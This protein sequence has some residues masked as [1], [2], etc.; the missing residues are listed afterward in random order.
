MSVQRIKIF[1]PVALVLAIG[2]LTGAAFAA[3]A[4][5]VNI[6]TAD[7]TELA[8]LPRVGP[9]L[10]ERI[11]LFR[12]ENGKFKDPAD[13]MLV[14]GIGERTFE[15]MEAYL[16]VEGETTLTQKVRTSDAER[17]LE[18]AQADGAD[19]ADTDDAQR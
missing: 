5:V 17:R 9:A 8:L 15:L 11:V 6:N 1:V 13:L 4:P 19:G 16:V 3:D 10:S 7:T 2:L 14:R 18:K 12:D